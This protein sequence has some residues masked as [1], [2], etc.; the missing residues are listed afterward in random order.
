MDSF[1]QHITRDQLKAATEA[2]G[3]PARS[4]TSFTADAR[5]GVTVTYLVRNEQGRLT[6]DA[7]GEIDA[8]TI[9]IPINDEVS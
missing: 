9:S 4:V 8:K 7:D 6:V 2:L 5:D 3:L 1:P